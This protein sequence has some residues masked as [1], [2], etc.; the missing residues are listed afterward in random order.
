M[1]LLQIRLLQRIVVSIHLYQECFVN[2]DIQ[3]SG[4]YS[5]RYFTLNSNDHRIYGT[6]IRVRKMDKRND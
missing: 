2:E 1:Y 3:W 5:K 6:F 4:I